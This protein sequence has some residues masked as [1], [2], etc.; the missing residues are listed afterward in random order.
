MSFMFNGEMK[1]YIAIDY[2]EARPFFAS[3]DLKL[4]E[5]PGSA[6]NILTG[7]KTSSRRIEVPVLIYYKSFD[8]LQRIKEDMADWLLHERPK[9]LKFFDEP[10]RVYRAILDGGFS[11]DER[12]RVG[13]GILSFLCP[14]PYKYGDTK[15]SAFSGQK[16]LNNRGTVS[17]LPILN[18]Y[19]TAPRTNLQIIN[20]GKPFRLIR[21]FVAGDRVVIDCE[22]G[23]VQLNGVDAMS[24]RD[25]RTPFKR[26]TLQPAL[27]EILS[28]SGVEVESVFTER[29]L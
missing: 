28:D 24:I 6:G 13:K 25:W 29:Y 2:S 11:L 8:E 17:A 23:L 20:N 9:E 18:I 10:N 16:T 26:L 7:I 4:S 12:L 5:V 27:N 3:R 21:E 1:N 14:D 19:F 15:S 22:K